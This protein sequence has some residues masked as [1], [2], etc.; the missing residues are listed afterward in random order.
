MFI[1]CFQLFF[2]VFIFF[3]SPLYSI[4]HFFTSKGHF[5][6]FEFFMSQFQQQLMLFIAQSVYVSLDVRNLM[7]NDAPT[8]SEPD[9]IEC[10]CVDVMND[11]PLSAIKI[12]K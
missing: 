11:L 4:I 8:I 3:V 12:D 7:I 5:T 2:N 6:I 9:D 10:D 1:N